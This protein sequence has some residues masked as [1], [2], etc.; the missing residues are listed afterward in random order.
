MN[1]I[2]W[3][4]L[5]EEI[6]KYI[7]R[8]ET[9]SFYG[10]GFFV[11][12]TLKG[13]IPFVNIATAYHIIKHANEWLESIKLTYFNT[14]KSILLNPHNQE[15]I[16]NIDFNNDNDLAIINYNALLLEINEKPPSLPPPASYIFPGF[17]IGWCGFPVLSPDKLCFFNGH[18][19]A[20]FNTEG[21]YLVDGT[22]INGV[23]GGPVFTKPNGETLIIGLVTN[24]FSNQQMGTSTPGLSLM[25]NVN[26][27]V[28]KITEKLSG[29]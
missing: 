7:F 27:I 4:V 25:R 9:P 18:I 20:L 24:Y 8:I 19:S 2:Q 14:G 12:K 23:S 16:Y 15:N 5:F 13:N 28:T 6:K 1:G 3:H 22:T 26:P 10:T 11:A 17:E 29:K 21:D